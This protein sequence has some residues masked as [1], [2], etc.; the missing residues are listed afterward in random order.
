MSFIII[1]H[2]HPLSSR[3]SWVKGGHHRVSPVSLLSAAVVICGSSLLF[4]PYEAAPPLQLSWHPLLRWCS[5]LPWPADGRARLHHGGC[6]SLYL[7]WLP[8]ENERNNAQGKYKPE[9]N[10]LGDL[11]F[12]LKKYTKKTT[13][14]LL[15]ILQSDGGHLAVLMLFSITNR[16]L[17]RNTP[18]TIITTMAVFL[19]GLL[20]WLCNS[21]FIHLII[22]F[23]FLVLSRLYVP[24]SLCVC[25]CQCHYFSL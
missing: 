12:N 15:H 17:T 9:N 8:Q 4:L 24:A 2:L 18:H 20:W 3:P 6:S 5:G 21:F 1:L 19:A 10:Y 16:L 14:S 13:A 7:Q 25:L 22:R 23:S 11:I